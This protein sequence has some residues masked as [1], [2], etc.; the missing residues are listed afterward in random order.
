MGSVWSHSEELGESEKFGACGAALTSSA[1]PAASAHATGTDF[2][3]ANDGTRVD[4]VIWLA[5]EPSS[6]L[7][8]LGHRAYT[9]CTTR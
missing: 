6:R 1:L 4:D 9:W 5:S 8:S 7:G 2:F 3:D